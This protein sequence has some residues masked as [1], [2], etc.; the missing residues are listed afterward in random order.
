MTATMLA[1]ANMVVAGEAGHERTVD[2]RQ[3]RVAARLRQRRR[4]GLP[5][6]RCGRGRFGRKRRGRGH[7][8]RF[9]WD[10]LEASA[11]GSGGVAG[12]D[13]SAGAP[14]QGGAAGKGGAAGQ[15][16]ADAGACGPNIPFFAPKAC[17]DCLHANCCPQKNVCGLDSECVALI[18][19]GSQPSCASGP[20]WQKCIQDHPTGYPDEEIYG[21]CLSKNCNPECFQDPG[22]ACGFTP[23]LVEA[24]ST[25]L[26]AA[27]CNEIY[28]ASQDPE[29]WA[30]GQCWQACASG[31]TTCQN[32]CYAQFPSGYQKET[33][34]VGCGSANCATEC[35]N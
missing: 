25:C 3:W 8:G 17:T 10:G 26:N 32:A 23:S 30:L 12:S 31:D 13:A 34:W 16:G 19:C 1:R 33:A 4:C 20:C 29:F 15:A 27:C 2:D 6:S 14:G 22:S 35:G 21:A 24:C 7:L 28:D 11:S 18:Q 9:G 5:W